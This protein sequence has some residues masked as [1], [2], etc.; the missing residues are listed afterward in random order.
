MTIHHKTQPTHESALNGRDPVTTQWREKYLVALEEQEKLEKQVAA[1]ADMLRRTVVHLS[2]ASNGLDKRLDTELTVFKEK[3]R[4]A[5]GASVNAQLTRVEQAV[6]KWHHERAEQTQTTCALLKTFASEFE[7]LRLDSHT[8][9]EVNNFKRGINT[10]SVELYKQFTWLKNLIALQSQALKVAAAPDQSLWQRLNGRTRLLSAP[11]EQQNNSN[12]AK[13]TQATPLEQAATPAQ[14]EPQAHSDTAATVTAS[15]QANAQPNNISAQPIDRPMTNN[16]THPIQV[17]ACD[18]ELNDSGEIE[19]LLHEIFSAIVPSEQLADKIVAARIQIDKGV[20]GDNIGGFLRDIRD[21]LQAS[22]MNYGTEFGNYLVHMNTELTRICQALDTHLEDAVKQM[23][24]REKDTQILEKSQDQLAAAN[25][26]TGIDDLKNAVMEHLTIIEKSLAQR[27]HE[28][29]STHASNEELQQVAK[30]LQ[31]V[32]V[33]AKATK[34]LME[35]EQHQANRDALT[36][37]PNRTGCSQRLELEWE[38]FQHYKHPMTLGMCNI[39]GLA[40][41]NEYGYIIGDR[42]LKLVA[43]T[44]R[45]RLRSVD[46]V[47]RYHGDKFLL[48]L[49]QTQPEEGKLTLEKIGQFLAKAPLNIKGQ[50]IQVTLSFSLTRFKKEESSADSCQR[51]LQAFDDAKAQGG[52]SIV[53]T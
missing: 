35:Q 21:I 28:Q 48:M 15:E 9:K 5:S 52:H 11:P 39:D 17:K 46:F 24:D 53:I 12:N 14:T 29:A 49:P 41:F 47:G 32:E 4:G 2:S 26:K 31:A 6:K 44:L 8:Q 13:N 22:Y 23:I 27:K 43:T 51:M 20:T 36:N 3:L 7:K 18:I 34:D 37:L 16:Q 10:Q 30:K 25:Q 38:R 40:I 1:H 50:P 42:V 45:E 19:Q 33:E